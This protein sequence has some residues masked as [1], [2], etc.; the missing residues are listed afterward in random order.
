MRIIFILFTEN[1][2]TPKDST[3]TDKNDDILICE[4]SDEKLEISDEEKEE[5]KLDLNVD[6]ENIKTFIKESM[7]VIIL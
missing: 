1:L 2:Q 3:L 4:V 7:I 6:D 5:L